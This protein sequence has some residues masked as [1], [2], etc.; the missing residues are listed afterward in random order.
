VGE[1]TFN[2]TPVGKVLSSNFDQWSFINNLEW[3]K[4][5]VKVIGKTHSQTNFVKLSSGEIR[6]LNAAEFSSALAAF[7]ADAD[8]RLV[9]QNI[10]GHERFEAFQL[11]SLKSFQ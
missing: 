11:M 2:N 9:Y 10:L 4:I 5:R 7:K 1:E 3:S 8:N 6:N